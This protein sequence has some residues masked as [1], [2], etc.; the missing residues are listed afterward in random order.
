MEN[1]Q[2]PTIESEL[3]EEIRRSLQKRKEDRNKELRDCPTC[4]K[5]YHPMKDW[6]RFCSLICRSKYHNEREEIRKESKV[7][8]LERVKLEKEELVKENSE[9]RKEIVR[10]DKRIKDLQQ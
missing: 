5:P 10:L 9:L 8:E 1:A 4:G 2:P 3:D 6:Q 7:H